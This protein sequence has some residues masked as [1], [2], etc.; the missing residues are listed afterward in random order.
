VL[1]WINGNGL[2]AFGRVYN[3]TFG[4]SVDFTSFTCLV[5]G[6]VLILMMLYKREGLIP[7]S[8]MKLLMNEDEFEAAESD[9]KKQKAG[10]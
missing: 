10:K 7:E 3:E 2:S 4:T 1:S 9:G 6:V 5:F 8:R